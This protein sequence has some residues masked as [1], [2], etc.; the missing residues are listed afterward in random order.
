LNTAIA[1]HAQWFFVLGDKVQEST[2]KTCIE[3]RFSAI[4]AWRIRLMRSA[5]AN[6]LHKI[7]Q[8]NAE[9]AQLYAAYQVP[10]R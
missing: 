2:E 6:A 10:T 8:F 4:D 7:T 3:A 1:N 9:A 5:Q